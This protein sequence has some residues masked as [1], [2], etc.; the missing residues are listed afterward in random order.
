M[1]VSLLDHVCYGDTGCSYFT[2]RSSAT[3]EGPTTT[4]L[5]H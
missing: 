5:V 1:F 2:T 3:A 4:M